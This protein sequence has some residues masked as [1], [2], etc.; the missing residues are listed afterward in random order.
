MADDR[1]VE[2]VGILNLFHQRLLKDREAGKES[3]L[4]EYQRAFPGYE[5]LIAADYERLRRVSISAGAL[6]D[7]GI[8]VAALLDEVIDFEPVP[9]DALAEAGIPERFGPYRVLGILGEGGMGTVVHARQTKPLQREV[10]IKVIKQGMDSKA[11]L[12]RFEGERNALALMHHTNI[13]SV[14]DAG[15]LDNGRPYFAMEYVPGH[16]LDEYC[17]AHRLG[18]R[19]RLGLFRQVCDGLQHAHQKAIIHRDIKPSNIRVTREGDRPLAKIID[20]GIAKSLGAPLHG[21]TAHTERGAMIGSYATMSPE[22]A[23]SSSDIDTRTDIYALGAVLYHLL[24][25]AY[26]IEHGLSDLPET[27]RKRISEEVPPRPSQRLRTLDGDAE[28]TAAKRSTTT[29]GLRRL[30]EGDLD[31]IAMKALE[32]ERE[33][34]YGNVADF[35]E[36]IEKF[37]ND[38]PVRARPPELSYVFGKFIRRH[39]R[40]LAAAGA[41]VVA[42]VLAVVV[43]G[44]VARAR[45]EAQCEEWLADGNTSLKELR[46]A[47]VE[48]KNLEA[49][50]AS[51]EAETPAWAPVWERREMIAL[52]DRKEALQR[53]LETLRNQAEFHFRSAF[54]AAEP[55]SL[56]HNDARAA[57]LGL[58]EEYHDRAK[59]WRGLTVKPEYFAFQAS[60]VD[61]DSTVGAEQRVRLDLRS[62]PPGAE[63]YCF[64]YEEHEERLLPMPFD[65]RAGREDPKLGVLGKP[66]LIVER[67]WERWSSGPAPAPER[68]QLLD[69]F[70]EGDRL[71]AIGPRPLE[72]LGDL[73]EAIEGVGRDIEVDVRL[74][75]GESVKDLRW[76][77]FPSELYELRQDPETEKPIPA[78]LPSPLEY[79]RLIDIRRQLGVT[80]SA[81]PLE[82]DDRCRL[83]ALGSSHSTVDLPPGSYLLVLRMP[84]YVDVRYP[85]ATPWR[86]PNVAVRLFEESEIPPGF[87]YI[88]GGPF[89]HGGDPDVDQSLDP[90][91]M[92]VPGFVI[93]RSEL[94]FRE[95]LEFLNDPEN[96]FEIDPQSGDAKLR[97]SEWPGEL[98]A[99]DKGDPDQLWSIQVIPRDQNRI[100]RFKWNGSQWDLAAGLN[101]TVLDLPLPGLSMIAALEY[102]R[103]LE[104]KH[105]GRWRFR[106][107][108]DYQWE[109]A[110]AGVD[111]RSHVW[112]QHFQATFC[113][114][115]MARYAPLP[116]LVRPG[117]FPTDQS[118]YG[119]W[120]LAGAVTEPTLG[121]VARKYV[122][123][124]GGGLAGT[125]YFF[126]I[127]NRNG[128]APNLSVFDGGLRIVAEITEK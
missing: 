32:K 103:W 40:A 26:P 15:L 73:A 43:A 113:N 19:E 13:A 116:W 127:A 109:K 44:E 37:L 38:E 112:G 65:A 95:F 128:R 46:E 84:G 121:V 8:D 35:A 31:W 6:D 79:G 29:T 56:V 100:L 50:L 63:V 83:A 74:R 94:T 108:S 48:A 11:V 10:A 9:I 22:Q 17:D 24:T 30:I 52:R 107:P 57:I 101:E 122:V 55:G 88:P 96:P 59:K 123:H 47:E 93:R 2:S 81:Y 1:R 77:P 87:V 45:T 78:L 72:L 68:K 16:D 114:S 5:D 3:S 70:E 92:D 27:I 54:A 110:A 89:F 90:G 28:D 119:V 80:F 18:V 49:S 125:E 105:G 118:V 34:R 64:R 120:D 71:L 25:G 67:L 60:L 61:E 39:R 126:R 97:S 58:L 12:A 75:R 42:A 69:P 62:E 111:R 82:F 14:Y 41:V 76:V 85:V 33:R 117:G 53:N 115:P 106:L 86:A 23:K 99:V 102:V 91:V 21:A 66:S 7:G 36:D 4:E 20:F 124:R 98:D 104:K 51:A